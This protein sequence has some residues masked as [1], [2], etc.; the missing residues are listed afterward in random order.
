MP[1]P[2]FCHQEAVNLKEASGDIQTEFY[3]NKASKIS[4]FSL[5]FIL[6]EVT[7]ANAVKPWTTEEVVER[8][9]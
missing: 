8:G 6:P 9:P 5:T 2:I 3:N 1:N 7:D 4:V